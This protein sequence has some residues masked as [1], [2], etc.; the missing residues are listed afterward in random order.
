MFKPKHQAGA[1]VEQHVSSK[2]RRF[3]A[4][5]SVRELTFLLLGE[6]GVGKS[7]LINALAN[8]LIFENLDDIEPDKALS[9]IPTK[10][11]LYDP[12]QVS[13]EIAITSKASLLDKLR[14]HSSR[15][16]EK[17]AVGQSSTQHPRTYVFDARLL[18][19]EP[20]RVKLID[21]PGMGDT[22]GVEQD[23]SNMDLIIKYIVNYPQ[24]NAILFLLKPNNSRLTVWFRLCIKELL[25]NLH[26]DSARN[27]MFMFT[28][29]RS[30]LYRP[31]D[32]MVSLSALLDVVQQDTGVHVPLDNSNIFMVDNE[33]Y[34]FLLARDKVQFAA[35][36]VAAFRNSWRR[37]STTCQSLLNAAASIPFHATNQT[38]NLYEVRRAVLALCQPLANIAADIASTKR[39][40]DD[41]T[42]ALN[43]LRTAVVDLEKTLTVTVPVAVKHQLSTLI[44]VCTHSDC[45]KH[46]EDEHGNTLVDYVVR[47]QQRCHLFHVPLNR[48]GDPHF[49][50]LPVMENHRCKKCQ[51]EYNFHMMTNSEVRY[52]PRPILSQHARNQIAAEAIKVHQAQNAIKS[53]HN[54]L[55]D[56][57]RLEQRI[58]SIG[59]RLADYIRHN[60]I[61]LYNDALL[62]YLDHLI[63]D[64]K[65]AGPPGLDGSLQSKTKGLERIRRL[66]EG[67]K[68]L[69]TENHATGGSGPSERDIIAVFGELESL[70]N[71]GG[72]FQAFELEA[73]LRS[74]RIG[75]YSLFG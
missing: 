54:I 20:V 48:V 62:D 7:T 26:R 44:V 34:R 3:S 46:V 47:C 10:F 9:L 32:T 65:D 5:T 68:R 41:Q 11:Y 75:V 38:I 56:L 37:S 4:I 25:K 45:V 59:S 2:Q 40:V 39:A 49:A 51:H 53:L 19:G 73:P 61:V 58:I 12:E 55:D 74:F 71:E 17:H 33:A 66:H 57:S 29:A 63:N 31:G 69:L 27:I 18:N 52:E 13:Q 43:S 28:N 35:E 24:I 30:T 16:N 36:D 8:Y 15:N 50:D 72:V 1:V 21:T 23:K 22:R 67:E 64:A 70:R 14:D 60:S 6:T 42:A